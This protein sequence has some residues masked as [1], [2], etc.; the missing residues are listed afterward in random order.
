MKKYIR[1]DNLN[2]NNTKFPSERE[3][4]E[5][6]ERDNQ[7]IALNIFSVP[8]QRKTINIQYRSRHIRTRNKQVNLLMITDKEKWHYIT[9]K[10]IP[11]LFRDVTSTNHGDRCCFICFQSY[12]TDDALK[13]HELLCEN[14]D[15]CKVI[16]PKEDKKN[17]IC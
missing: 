2:W 5:R 8:Y 1:N 16:L 13:N 9:I 7:N 6:F 14:N 3:D 4:W 15:Y 17:G 12:R 10:S 11:A